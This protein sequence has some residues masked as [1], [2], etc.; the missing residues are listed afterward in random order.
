MTI[1]KWQGTYK[2][3]AAAGVV[4]LGGCNAALL[5]PKGMVGMDQRNLIITAFILMMLVVIPVII[6]TFVF[7]WKYRESN[8]KARYE[9][10]WAHSNKLE[11]VVWGV[12]III[13]IALAVITWESSHSLDPQKPIASNQQPIDVEVVALD[14]KWLFIYPQYGIATINELAVP[15]DT[16]IRFSITSDTVMNS[17]FIPQLGSQIYAMAGM[18]SH[19]N[20]IANEPGTYTGISANFSGNGFYGMHFQTIAQSNQDFQSWVNRVRQSGRSLDQNAY[21]GLTYPSMKNPPEF[22][23]SV[24]P[25]LFQSIVRS[26]NGNQDGQKAPGVGE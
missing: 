24:E 26:F 23:S 13:I 15:V 9:P 7:A 2:P 6:M 11:A 5:D 21:Q 1:K 10:N 14:W 8:T 17:F 3:L 18:T 22:F 12:P 20:L 4:M 19:L 25:N 16:P